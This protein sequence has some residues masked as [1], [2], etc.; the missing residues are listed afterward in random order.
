MRYSAN[1]GFS[2]ALTEKTT[3]AFQTIGFYQPNLKVSGVVTPQSYQE[4]Y[5]ARGALTVRVLDNT[6]VEPSIAT[7][8]TNESPAMNVGVTFR[9]R[10]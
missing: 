8:L 5:I 9:K 6:W 4:Q 1:V 3:L 2:F 10:W 7:G